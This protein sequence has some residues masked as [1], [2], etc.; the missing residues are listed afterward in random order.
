MGTVTSR[1]LSVIGLPHAV[2]DAHV[3][4]A[5]ILANRSRSPY[6]GSTNLLRRLEPTWGDV[7]VL[8]KIL[9]R[10]GPANA[11]QMLAAFSSASSSARA[12]Q[13]I[14]NGA[15]HNHTQN[16][17][18]IMLLQSAYFAFP[19]THA[20]HAMFWVEPVSRDFLVTHAIEELKDAGIAATE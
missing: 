18:E 7:D 15:A 11:G 9:P 1:G 14:R 3:S 8:A 19:I 20:V 13:R 6:W 17:D 2:S 16:L 5:A 4:N 12:L 10:L